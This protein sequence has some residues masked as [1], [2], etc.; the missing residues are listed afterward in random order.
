[1][2]SCSGSIGILTY[3]EN[4]DAPRCFLVSDR[5][6]PVNLAKGINKQVYEFPGTGIA[7]ILIN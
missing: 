3:G 1:M 5:G 4:L 7:Q 2:L 6:D